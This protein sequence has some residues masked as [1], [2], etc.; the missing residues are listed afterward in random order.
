MKD[1]NKTTDYKELFSTQNRTFIF[2]EIE[3]I[4]LYW[5]FK[6]EPRTAQSVKRQKP[7][8]GIYFF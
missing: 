3:I 8:L 7:A 1:Q 5:G 2:V 4:V 6:P